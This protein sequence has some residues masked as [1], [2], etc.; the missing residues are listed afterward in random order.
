VILYGAAFASFGSFHGLFKT[1]GPEQDPPAVSLLGQFHTLFFP[2]ELAKFS[3]ITGS[4]I[5]ESN[6]SGKAAIP[7]C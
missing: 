7:D 3:L 2:N 1:T 6:F 5:G 4:Y